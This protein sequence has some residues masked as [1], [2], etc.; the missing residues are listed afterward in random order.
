LI[1]P[2]YNE[3]A[4]ISQVI[5]DF[6]RELPEAEI[7]VFDNNSTDNTVKTA[8]EA[9]A[10]VS[11]ERRQ[12]KGNVVR[13]MFQLVD[14]DIYIMVDGDSTYP[15]DRI[16]AL[17]SPVLEGKADM[18]VGS[19][20]M[21]ARSE[22]KNLNWWGNRLFLFA[23]NTTFGC[24]LTDILSGYRVM[25]R[26]FVR[27]MPILS[28][29]FQIEAELTIEALHFDM[30]IIEMPVILRNRPKG[31][32]SKI[33]IISD[34]LKILWTIFDLFRNVKPLTTF[35]GAGLMMIA[36]GVVLGVGVIV[37]FM[38]TGMVP[39]FPT[40]ILATGMVLSGLLSTAIGL[41][42]NTLARNFKELRY[43]LTAID[44]RVSAESKSSAR[45]Q[46]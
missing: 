46:P 29:G 20:L 11:Y 36:I 12:G 27:S 39:R 30:R 23:V 34:G 1:I 16:H 2:C 43:F 32:E 5:A 35:G 38:Q 41:I 3:E 7:H 18:V 45:I 17:L 44:R 22:M 14:A 6:K 15:A 33:H 8:S 9:G 4:A 42:L 25:T 19:R 37:E 10:I 21:S 24:R 13:S 28:K 26:E 31:G 40:A